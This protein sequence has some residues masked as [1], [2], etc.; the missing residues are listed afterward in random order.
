MSVGHRGIY[1]RASA[2]NASRK[3]WLVCP[4]SALDGVSDTFDAKTQKGFHQLISKMLVNEA[5]LAFKMLGTFGK[6]L[7]EIRV[8]STWQQWQIDSVQVL[9]NFIKMHSGTQSLW[10]I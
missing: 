3:Q 10:C 1:S 7:W 8:Q 2:K 6:I 4:L 9:E 5:T